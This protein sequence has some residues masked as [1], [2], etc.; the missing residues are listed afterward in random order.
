MTLQEIVI[1]LSCMG[2]KEIGLWGFVLD[3]TTDFLSNYSIVKL[4]N[5]A[6]I[7]SIFSITVLSEHFPTLSDEKM[8][9]I[10]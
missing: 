10:S 2:E 3:S 8:I 5:F 9:E 7:P 1:T 6:G 4:V